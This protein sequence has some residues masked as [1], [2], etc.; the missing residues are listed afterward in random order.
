MGQAAWTLPSVLR[1]GVVESCEIFGAERP[2]FDEPPQV[3]LEGIELPGADLRG[4]PLP[5]ENMTP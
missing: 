5:G 3:R 4:P 1:I 2:A